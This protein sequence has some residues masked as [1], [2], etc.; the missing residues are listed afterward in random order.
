MALEEYVNQILA[1]DCQVY[2]RV[3]LRFS[4]QILWVT[5]NSVALNLKQEWKVS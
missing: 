3:Q 5:V 1:N 4:C 2:W